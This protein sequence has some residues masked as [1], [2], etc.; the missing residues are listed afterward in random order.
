MKRALVTLF[1]L[2][3][4]G[5]AV[6]STQAAP[7]IQ[8]G[9]Y[10]ETARGS[11][12]M[13]FVFDGLG[14][15]TGQ[16]FVGTAAHCVEKVGMD[17]KDEDGRVIGDAAVLGWQ[18]KP[19]KVAPLGRDW[20]LVKIRPP[21]VPRV[22]AAM[23]GHP[24]FPKGVTS[25]TWT[26]QGQPVQLSGYGL[27]F[28]LLQF[29]RETRTAFMGYDDTRTYDVIGPIYKG[30]S[31]GPLVYVPTGKALGIVSRLCV[32]VC[33]EYGPTIQGMLLQLKQRGWLVKLRSV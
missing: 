12:T 22:R 11:C 24:K 15:R 23:K 28:N 7:V 21:F 6:P 20:A 26:E 1:A 9:A 5:V 33:T 27:P 29:T 13:N 31:G 16:V 18:G 19:G 3:A 30:D 14:A 2:V 32:G 10:M 4:G 17:V 8:P 25:P